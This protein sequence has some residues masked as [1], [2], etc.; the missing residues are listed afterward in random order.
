MS[1]P[2]VQ[3]TNG[4]FGRRHHFGPGSA[5][6]NQMI[7]A[8]WVLCRGGPGSGKTDYFVSDFT[9]ILGAY[10]GRPDR[11]PAQDYLGK[12]G[13]V[14]Q[15]VWDDEAELWRVTAHFPN[16]EVE[17]RSA[18]AVLSG[19]GILN[20]PYTPELP[21]LDR[22]GGPVFHSAEWDHSVDVTGKRVA[23]IG[24]GASGFQIG[25]AI[26]ADVAQLTVFQRT[27]QWMAPNPR[28]HAAVQPGEQWAMR[29]LP[30]YSRWYRFMLT[31]QSN[32][33]LLELVRADPEWADFPH[34]ANTESTARRE[35]FDQWIERQLGDDSELIAKATPTYPPMA[36]RMLQDNGSWLRCLTQPHVDLVTDAITDIDA[37][38]VSTAEGRYDADIIVLAT[39]FRAS[40]VL[41]PM[42]IIGRDGRSI[43]DVWDGKPAAYNGVSVA[44]FPNFFVMSG[45]GTGLAHGGSVI[46]MSECQMRYIGGALRTLIDGGHRSIEPTAAA[47]E[48][49][50]DDLLAEV[51]T[52][53][54][55]HPSIEHSWYKADGKVFILCPWRLVD[56]WQMTGSVDPD[57]HTI[58]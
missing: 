58:L 55:G 18:H 23:L 26:V 33:K 52:L 32:D 48:R 38:S 34:T 44:G 57:D 31:W 28:Y 29:H 20:R 1:L 8:L 22:F 11:N 41:W 27:P 3:Q 42:E 25:P 17:T 36:K 53:M 21:N 10:S 14:Q 56:Y 50:R 37:T 5:R 7:L 16:G 4:Q 43:A 13:E 30:G 2:F 40:D 47:Y 12:H 46:V 49:Y 6:L 45:P 9:C 19:V 51:A 15:A 35:L 54:W 24:A 39:G